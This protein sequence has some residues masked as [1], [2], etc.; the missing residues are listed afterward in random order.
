[1][2]VPVEIGASGGSRVQSPRDEQ[3]WLPLGCI[4][5][6]LSRSLFLFTRFCMPRKRRELNFSL[7]GKFDEFS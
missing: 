2:T 3:P 5:W 1:M 4:C 6:I 7:T